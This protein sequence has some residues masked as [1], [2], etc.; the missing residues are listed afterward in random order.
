MV[1]CKPG[2]LVHHTLSTSKSYI[3]PKTPELLVKTQITVLPVAI[4][5]IPIIGL[6]L[7]S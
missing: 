1:C 5:V 4:I 7:L 2:N 3:R 6:V